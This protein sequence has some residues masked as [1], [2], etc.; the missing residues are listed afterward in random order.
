MVVLLCNYLGF[1]GRK[2]VERC[3]ATAKGFEREDLVS[4]P[5]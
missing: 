1:T 2:G 3:E 4:L 5:R